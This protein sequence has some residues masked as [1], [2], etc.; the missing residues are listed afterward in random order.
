VFS[1]RG[2]PETIS[3]SRLAR[4]GIS[5]KRLS[6]RHIDGPMGVRGRNSDNRLIREKLGWAPSA[7][8]HAGLEKM[9]LWIQAQVRAAVHEL[10]RS[11]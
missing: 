9:Y 1:T 6:I 5:G 3:S 8:L 7:S 10:V 4:I 2:K 11:S